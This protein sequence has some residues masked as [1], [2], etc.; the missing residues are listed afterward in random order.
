[1]YNDG[2]KP[3]EPI[4]KTLRLKIA[5]KPYIA[6]SLGPKALKYESLEPK[7]KESQQVD[8]IRFLHS[9]NPTLLEAA[10]GAGKTPVH[11]AAQRVWAEGSGFKAYW[12][13]VCI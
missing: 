13:T 3:T 6:W 9:A 1:M 2:R 12:D 8:V 10:D 4:S 11:R 7:G 5:Q